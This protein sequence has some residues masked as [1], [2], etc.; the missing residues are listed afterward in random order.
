VE[1]EHRSRIGFGGVIGGVEE[2]GAEGG[3]G[4]VEEMDGE[5]GGEVL[6]DEYRDGWVEP[7]TDR[8]RR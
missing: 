6:N 1:P 7:K 5:D 3:C 4:K 2:L 8:M